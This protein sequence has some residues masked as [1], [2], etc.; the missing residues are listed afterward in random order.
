V[1]Q[2][3]LI[4]SPIFTD[5]T[6]VKSGGPDNMSRGYSEFLGLSQSPRPLYRKCSAVGRTVRKQDAALSDTV[7]LLLRCEAA[8]PTEVGAL[9]HR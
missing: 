8:R 7:S 2:N 6:V 1:A 4:L 3:A 9:F 5:S